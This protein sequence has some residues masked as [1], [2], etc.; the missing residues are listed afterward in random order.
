QIQHAVTTRDV[1]LK[2]RIE[3]PAKHPVWS[4]MDAEYQRALPIAR[5]AGRPHQ[6]TLNLRAVEAAE[7]ELVGNDEPHRSNQRVVMRAHPTH[8]EHTGSRTSPDF[9]RPQRGAEGH[10]KR[11]RDLASETL[12]SIT[13]TE[14]ADLKWNVGEQRRTANIS[15]VH[16]EIRKC[17]DDLA[18]R[19]V[20]PKATDLAAVRSNAKQRRVTL[21]VREIHDPAAIG[22]PMW[23]ANTTVLIDC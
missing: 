3:R 20:N 21:V 18:L 2:R 15:Q 9:R 14:T 11:K 10:D 13:D 8:G 17:A 6:P 4:T 12:R 19:A 22:R 23:I 1:N 7:Y 5:A 16:I